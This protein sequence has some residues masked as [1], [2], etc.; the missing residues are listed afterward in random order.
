MEIEQSIDINAPAETLFT[1]LTDPERAKQWMDSVEET[2]FNPPFDPNR[3]IGAVFKQ[4]VKEMGRSVE[5]AGTI[6]GFEPS[7]RYVTKLEHHRFTLVV[8]WGLVALPHGTRLSYKA[9]LLSSDAMVDKLSK[10]FGWYARKTA[11]SQMKKLKN[12]LEQGVVR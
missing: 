10:A 9:N 7:R 3:P 4:R 1:W 8:D 12:I 2:T 5:Y 11:E 6:T